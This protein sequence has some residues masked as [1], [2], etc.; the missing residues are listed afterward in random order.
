MATLNIYKDNYIDSTIVSNCFIDEYM[1]DANDAQ[2]KIYLYLLRLIN[3]NL[4]A[5]I[6][7]MADKFN[8]TEKDV[9][10]ALKYWEKKKLL[11]LDFDE[12]KTLIG[13]HFNCNISSQPTQIAEITPFKVPTQHQENNTHTEN[14]II[15]KENTPELEVIAPKMEAMIPK[16]EMIPT[17]EVVSPY[18][19][20][21]YN[22]DQLKAFKEKENTAQLLFIAQT[23][24]GKPL[25][26][27]DMKTLL[28]ILDV[29]KFSEDLVDYLIQYCVERGKKDFRYIEKVA[30]NWAE[31]GITTPKEAE[32]CIH[33]H[34]G[35]VYAIMNALGRNSAPTNKE[36]EFI[37]RWIKEYHF[38]LD[39]ILEA[40]GRTVLATEKHRFEYTEGILCN[41]KKKNVRHKA[42]IIKVDELHQKQRHTTPQTTTN[43]FNTFKQNDY[44]FD[45]LE[46]ELLS[47]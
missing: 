31:S 8:H 5:S 11:G 28:Y 13:I 29:L 30:L 22:L 10:R 17:I 7:S 38:P 23:Y 33:K 6:S 32:K 34:D 4:P 43:K 39:V 14:N 3:G 1:S 45:E 19:K 9:L 12:N 24:L 21:V 40:C 37:T 26:S 42:D 46:K 41:W 27:S 44:D 15:Q 18:I 20:P 36:V 47:N 35:N 2:L 25:S 16:E